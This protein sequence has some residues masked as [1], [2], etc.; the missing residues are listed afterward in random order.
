MASQRSFFGV[1]GN[2]TVRVV[3]SDESGVGSKK[4]EPI[5]VVTAVLMNMDKCWPA[6]ESELRKIATETPKNLLYEERELKGSLLY[7]AAGKNIP[8]APKA[9]EI[10]ARVLAITINESIPVFYGAVDRVGYDAHAS[11]HRVQGADP[12]KEGK[13]HDRAFDA[14]AALVDRFASGFDEHVLWIADRSDPTRERTTKVALSW[15]QSLKA[16]GWDPITYQF[17]KPNYDHVRIADVIYFGHSH[18]SLALQLADVCCRTITLHLLEKFYGWRPIVGPF[19]EMIRVGLMND[20]EP[21]Y[22]DNLGPEGHCAR[23]FIQSTSASFAN[24]SGVTL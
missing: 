5:T 7:S 6:V 24:S 12:E 15:M 21:E 9:R 17:I 3:Y 11:A 13:A 14:C 20:T 19:Y 10:L 23:F 18:E 1:V 4:D 22:R 16:H 2:K 8:E